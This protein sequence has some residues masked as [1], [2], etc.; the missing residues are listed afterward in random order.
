L[1]VNG[2]PH[3]NMGVYDSRLAA[4]RRKVNL[5]QILDQGATDENA[6]PVQLQ[7]HPLI[8]FN[9]ARG[10]SG[11][12][13]LVVGDVAGVDGFYGEGIGASL[14]YGKLATQEINSAFSSRDFTFQ[15]YK[16]QLMSSRLGRYLFIRWLIAWVSYRLGRYAI[17]MHMSWI[18]GKILIAFWQEHEWFFPA[19]KLH[20]GER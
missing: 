18:A 14:A 2:E 11:T 16:K 20:D 15:E 19:Q 5:S 10:L 7:G 4:S 3:W 9:P 12:R 17:Y 8:S 6:P 13:F 1:L